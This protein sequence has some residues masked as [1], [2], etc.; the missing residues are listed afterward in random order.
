MGPALESYLETNPVACRHAGAKER[1][2]TLAMQQIEE[3]I[4]EE[5]EN[6][7]CDGLR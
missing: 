4:E 7:I 3:R 1:I 2:S 6:A 5:Y